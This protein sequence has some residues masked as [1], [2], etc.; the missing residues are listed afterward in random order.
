M[1]SRYSITQN[2]STEPLDFN[3]HVLKYVGLLKKSNYE[4]DLTQP[5]GFNDHMLSYADLLKKLQSISDTKATSVTEL[6][7]AKKAT[8]VTELVP[9]KKAVS[10]TELVPATKAVPATKLVPAKKAVSKRKAIQRRGSGLN[11]LKNLG[12]TCY[13]N[14]VL[15]GLSNIPE[16]VDYFTEQFTYEHLSDGQSNQGRLTLSFSALMKSIWTE[17]SSI[18]KNLIEFRSLIGTLR[19]EFSRSEQQDAQEFFIFLVDSLKE[20]LRN[21]KVLSDIFDG[22][23][24]SIRTCNNC[25]DFSSTKESF[26]DIQLD[27][28][29]KNHLLQ[30]EVKMQQLWKNF[31]KEETVKR[32]CDRCGCEKATKAIGDIKLP[33]V[34]TLQFKRFSATCNPFTGELDF[35]KIMTKVQYPVEKLKVRGEDVV[36][37]ELVGS[38]FHHGSSVRGGHYTARCRNAFTSEWYIFNDDTVAPLRNFRAPSSDVY[39]L[40]FRRI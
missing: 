6:V 14:S 32:Q 34:L 29:E 39:L 40:F 23:Y 21:K 27:F 8:S 3:D 9:A 7:P 38:V 5:L 37:Y 16:I 20:S 13:M 2:D 12:N 33:Q 35:D 30:E 22:E 19:E 26:V 15:Q 4:R 18:E 36:Y 24:T 25:G 11:G 1:H 10:V 31:F 17:P 28:Q